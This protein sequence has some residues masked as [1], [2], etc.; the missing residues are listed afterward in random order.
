MENSLKQLLLNEAIR[1]GDELL[2]KAEVA[3]QGLSWKSL[4][5]QG[6]HISWQ[7]SET[8]YNGVCGIVLFLAELFNQ[9]R[10]QK[11]RQA[12][13]EGGRWVEWYCRQHP[14]DNAAFLTG[15]MSVPYTYLQLY[16]LTRQPAYLGKALAIARECLAVPATNLMEYINGAAGTQLVLLQLHAVTRETWLLAHLDRY[17]EALIS[18]GHMGPK[19]IYWDRSPM[20]IHGLCGLSH[21]A[22]GIGY[23]LLELG[24]YVQ[25]PAFYWLARQAF[26]YESF[27]YDPEIH[28]WY[29]YRKM[30]LTRQ[31]GTAFRQAYQSGDA[32]FFTKG[33]S[34]NA[35][36]HGAAGI[37]LSRLRAF[38]VLHQPEYEA[39][40]QQALEHSL[41]KSLEAGW[42]TSFTLCHGQGGNAELFL[43]AYELYGDPA[44]LDMAEEVA[45]DALQ[46]RQVFGY[47]HSGTSYP[48][49][50][51]SLFMGNAG[52]GYFY[53]RVLQPRRVPSVLLPGVRPGAPPDVSA[54]PNLT[55]TVGAMEHKL[56]GRIFSHTLSLLEQLLPREVD[57]YFGQRKASPATPW[58][59]DFM[60]WAQTRTAD[61]RE[62][63]ESKLLEEVLQIEKRKLQIDQ[64]ITSDALLSFKNN[65]KR[66]RAAVLAAM[67]GAALAEVVLEADPDLQL[68]NTCREYHTE[69]QAEGL[70]TVGKHGGAYALLL[71]P[72]TDYTQE[73]ELSDFTATVLAAFAE[74]R[75]VAAG[76]ELLLSQFVVLSAA[77]TAEAR[78]LI[79][80]QIRQTLLAGML[81]EPDQH[82]LPVIALPALDYH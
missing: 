71:I 21:G 28:N 30:I 78:Q 5:Q 66:Q 41:A 27:F 14:A 24:Q 50:D 40:A 25:N 33:S 9:T 1:I 64:A 48:G 60:R 51:T 55:L 52:I 59:K 2:A 16:R 35:W 68:I 39:E 18:H 56:A 76:M 42:K 4:N 12:A 36:C 75:T 29:D 26:A 46:S 3:P 22:S 58:A 62:A 32:D 38:E 82:P 45:K 63:G 44:Y 31:D 70:S 53:L 6:H 67:P 74:A 72:S 15:R 47:Y 77:Q 57:H 20:N 65:R 61:L 43:K 81:L 23:V 17:A 34:M 79:L 37:G 8:I 10:Q 54:C 7:Q 69:R 49:E 19:G 11:Y 13:V 73:L 80:A